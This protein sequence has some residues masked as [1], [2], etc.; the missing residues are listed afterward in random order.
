[1]AP[2]GQRTACTCPIGTYDRTQGYIFCFQ[3]EAHDNPL[4][5]AAYDLARV[6]VCARIKNPSNPTSTFTHDPSPTPNRVPVPG[7]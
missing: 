1:M 2:N 4:E 7:C 6:C 3:T 5:A